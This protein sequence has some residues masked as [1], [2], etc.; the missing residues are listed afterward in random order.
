MQ[1]YGLATPENIYEAL[2]L[3]FILVIVIGNLVGL[4]T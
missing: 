3:Y 2:E 1:H 4:F